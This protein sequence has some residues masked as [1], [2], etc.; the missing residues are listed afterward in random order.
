M[1]R[2]IRYLSEVHPDARNILFD[3]DSTIAS[4]PVD[5]PLAR[6]EFRSYLAETF[7]S[8]IIPDSARVDEM[9]AIALS[10]APNQKDQVFQFRFDLESALDG[11]HT[12]LAETCV[13]IEALVQMPDYRL[14]VISN[15]LHRTVEVGLKQLGLSEAFE[16]ILGVDDSGAP[17]PDTAAFAMLQASHGL[18]PSKCIFVG[19]NDRTDGGFCRA[20]DIPFINIKE[21]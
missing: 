11:G 14:F 4:V 17:K 8:L 19:D 1:N 13:L 9:E 21:N 5:W 2:L 20:L 7:P 6:I 12:P 18:I 3:Y 15:N 10:N 16:A